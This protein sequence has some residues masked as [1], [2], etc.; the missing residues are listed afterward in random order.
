MKPITAQG[1]R[2]LVEDLLRQ[3]GLIRPTQ[4]FPLFKLHRAI[5]RQLQCPDQKA[6]TEQRTLRRVLPDGPFEWTVDHHYRRLI[7]EQNGLVWSVAFIR[8]AAGKPWLLHI[9]QSRPCQRPKS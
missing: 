1:N 3:H 8:S 5:D 9:R 4:Q 7:V 6:I 2:V